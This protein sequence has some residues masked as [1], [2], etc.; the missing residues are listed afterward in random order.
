[1][2]GLYQAVAGLP[3][4]SHP[5][6]ARGLALLDATGSA[7]ASGSLDVGGAYAALAQVR[8]AFTDAQTD[9][10][11]GGAMRGA[12]ACAAVAAAAPLSAPTPSTPLDQLTPADLARA[13]SERPA[14]KPDGRR[15]NAPPPADPH[16]A[17]RKRYLDVLAKGASLGAQAAKGAGVGIFLASK[18]ISANTRGA[19][20]HLHHD[21]GRGEHMRW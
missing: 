12:S 5:S 9:L 6:V 4:L 17:A 8:S 7:V 14:P 21:G 13:A 2:A 20:Q 16:V 19:H 11:N 15:G 1:M 3:S 18:Y 10:Q